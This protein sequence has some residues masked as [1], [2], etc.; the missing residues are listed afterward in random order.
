V[1]SHYNQDLV[2]TC[3]FKY[4]NV[5]T[6]V[7]IIT[8]DWN[9]KFVRTT[10]IMGSSYCLLKYQHAVINISLWYVLCVNVRGNT[11]LV[12]ANIVTNPF[13]LVRLGL[14]HMATAPDQYSPLSYTHSTFSRLQLTHWNM[15]PHTETGVPKGF[16]FWS[17]FQLTSLSPP[18]LPCCN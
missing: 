13:S 8:T 1:T 4:T 2:H 12:C 6:L 9:I 3:N 7:C 17:Q 14:D 18:L 10:S 11:N 16:W 15:K 5:Q